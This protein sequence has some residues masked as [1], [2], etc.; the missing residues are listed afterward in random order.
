MAK[1]N[2][3]KNLSPFFAFPSFTH[4]I[5]ISI[6]IVLNDIFVCANIG[7]KISQS[8]HNNGLMR[9]L[10]LCFARRIQLLNIL[11]PTL[12]MAFNPY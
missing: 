8:V 1:K 11:E 6:E 2:M 4:T 7:G 9:Y 5:F 3:E 10:R 12:W